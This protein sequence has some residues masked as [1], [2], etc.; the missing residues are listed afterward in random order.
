[1]IKRGLYQKKHK[2]LDEFH[3]KIDE[4]LLNIDG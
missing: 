3:K 2:T 4:R 1:M